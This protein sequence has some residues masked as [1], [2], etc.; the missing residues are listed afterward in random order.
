MS[1]ELVDQRCKYCKKYSPFFDETYCLDRYNGILQDALHQLKYQ[2]RVAFAHGLATAWNQIQADRLEQCDADY[3]LPVPLSSQK[4]LARGFNQSWELA[5]RVS[6]N[7][8][9]QKLPYALKRHHHENHQAGNSFRARQDAIYE[10]FYID[11]PYRDRLV[12]KTVI[13]FD[14]VMTTGATLNEIA[15]IL[16]T[17]GVLRVINWVILRTTRFN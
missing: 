6:C 14:D 3:L 11:A 13:L 10:M 2:K 4:L 1:Q 12:N 16:K 9:M 7:G 15:R 8:R 5:R 17:I